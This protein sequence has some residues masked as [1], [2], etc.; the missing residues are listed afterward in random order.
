MT[1]LRM[2]PHV[3]ALIGVKFK[4]AEFIE[5]NTVLKE[6]CLVILVDL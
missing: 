6:Y 1:E 4:Q 3:N 2:N 5:K